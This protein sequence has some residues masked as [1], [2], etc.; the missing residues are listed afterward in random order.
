MT[1]LE[2]IGSYK[3]RT[4]AARL[5]E[6]DASGH[7]CRTCY[8]SSGEEGVWLEVHH[9]TYERLGHELVGDLTALC[10]YCHRVIT[11][12]H[13]RRRYAASIRPVAVD[14]VPLFERRTPLF[15]PTMGFRRHG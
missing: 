13:R 11:D 4:S 3:W 9:R 7:R 12:A 15:D 14:T 5:A 6:L 8:A 2:Y 10:S 1:Y